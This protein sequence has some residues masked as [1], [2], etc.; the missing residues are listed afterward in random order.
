VYVSS[1][2]VEGTQLTEIDWA[3]EDICG[4]LSS[5]KEAYNSLVYFDLA[6]ESVGT[7]DDL[8]MQMKT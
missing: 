2:E 7:H 3:I 4:V 5:F 8:T 6:F 1:I